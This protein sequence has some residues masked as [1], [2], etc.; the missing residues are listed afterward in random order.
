M[1]YTEFPQKISHYNITQPLGRGENTVVYL[2]FNNKTNQRV[3]IKTYYGAYLHD[4]LFQKRFNRELSL[5]R[6]LDHPNLVK[7][8]DSGVHNDIPFIVMEYLTGLTLQRLIAHH[9]TTHP[10][11]AINIMQQILDA[12]AYLHRADIVH[13]DIKP[14]AVFINTKGQV[15]LADF[16]IAKRVDDS[17]V[18][19]KGTLVGSP[20]YMSPEQRLGA[21]ST[22]R[23][24]IFSAGITFYEMLV[25]RTPWDNSDFL[26][27]DR[28]AWAKI[29]P[30]AKFVPEIDPGIDRII[31]KAIDLQPIRRYANAQEMLLDVQDLPSASFEDLAA[32]ARGRKI[33]SPHPPAAKSLPSPYVL[34]SIFLVAVICLL[35]GAFLAPRVIGFISPSPTATSTLTATITP[36]ITLTPTRQIFTLIVDTMARNSITGEPVVLP[37]G[38]VIIIINPT[39]TSCEILAAWNDIQVVVPAKVI[40][41]D[42][43]C[44]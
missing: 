10:L 26:P 30:V 18:T 37:K 8:Y 4:V 32:W 19:I 24:D 35:S 40:F 36:T 41:P 2:A 21:A 3:A 25:G 9:R 43:N 34:F 23:S 29:I 11:I 28:R 5:I 17:S 22:T 39:F 20:S 1:E 38:S 16:D 7:Y 33:S 44:P 42:N 12:L 13:R 6:G 15:K 14:S 27:T 31:I